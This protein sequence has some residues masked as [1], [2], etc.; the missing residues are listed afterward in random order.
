[1]KKLGTGKIKINN[2]GF[3]LIE[4]MITM[5]VVGVA[6]FANMNLS[7]QI[8]QNLGRD[9]N[10]AIATELSAN[11]M[12]ELMIRNSSDPVL[13]PGQHSQDYDRDQMKVTSGLFT[14]SWLVTLDTPM[15]SVMRIDVSVSIHAENGLRPIT[16]TSFRGE[17]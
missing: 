14:V 2:K 10:T 8:S 15:V 16:V 1:M 12:E 9:A 7:G 6:I 3:S 5:V 4:V 17:Q 11:F 13:S